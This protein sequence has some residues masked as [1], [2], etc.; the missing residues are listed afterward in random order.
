MT[1]NLGVGVAVLGAV[2]VGTIG[3]SDSDVVAGEFSVNRSGEDR[4]VVRLAQS[5]PVLID[6]G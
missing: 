3:R 2:A 4:L 6:H 5:L 1:L